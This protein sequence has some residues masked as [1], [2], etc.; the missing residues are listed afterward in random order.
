MRISVAAV[1]VSF[2]VI[3]GC[4]NAAG[5]QLAPLKVEDFQIDR[6]YLCQPLDEVVRFYGEPTRV[7]KTVVYEDKEDAGDWKR[8]YFSGIELEVS[9]EPKKVYDITVLG[10][11]LNTPRGIGVGTKIDK[12]LSQ[13]GKAE[14][15]GESLV[16]QLYDDTSENTYVLEFVVANSEVA[17]I[18]LY[19]AWD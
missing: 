1:L 13:Y 14:I 9:G 15:C 3:V 16:Y 17:R 10:A 12:V 19:F 7:G 11:G 2:L 8:Y 6:L 18:E 4:S 5:S